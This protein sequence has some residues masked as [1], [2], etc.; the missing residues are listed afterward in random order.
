MLVSIN[1]LRHPPQCV[2]VRTCDPLERVN[3][4]RK[5]GAQDALVMQELEKVVRERRRKV[6]RVQLLGQGEEGLRSV[7]EVVNVCAALLQLVCQQATERV[8]VRRTK[9]GLGHRQVVLLQV[10]VQA[11][12][13]RPEVG[14]VRASSQLHV[15]NCKGNEQQTY[16][17]ADVEMPAPACRPSQHEREGEQAGWC[18]P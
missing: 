6:A 15:C 9:D 2:C 1:A 13:R 16:M 10:G 11:R 17:P 8:R 14:S 18:A 3:V 4:L 5:D 12:L 7:L